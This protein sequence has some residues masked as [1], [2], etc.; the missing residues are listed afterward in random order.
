MGQLSVPDGAIIY[1]DTAPIIYSI[2][3]YLD[4]WQLLA[5]IW[6]KMESGSIQLI[7]SE[8]LLLE[9]LVIPLRTNNTVLINAYEQF[10]SSRITLFPIRDSILRLAAQFRAT[11]NLKTPDAIHAATALNMGCTLFLTNDAG[12]RTVPGLSVTVLK[13]VLNA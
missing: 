4:Y 5:P 8:L 11:N 7:S 10:L 9:C 13:D 6:E 3:C 2:E 12:L 1:L